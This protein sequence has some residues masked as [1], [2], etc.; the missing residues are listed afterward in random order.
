MN[1]M[2]LVVAIL[3]LAIA[4]PVLAADN[5]GAP[6]EPELE[7]ALKRLAREDAGAMQGQWIRITRPMVTCYSVV[8]DEDDVSWA[9]SVVQ[10]VWPALQAWTADKKLPEQCAGLK[11]GEK[12][13][14]AQT[15]IPNVVT[16]WGYCLP[17]CS[18]WVWPQFAPPVKAVG[19]YFVPTSPPH[20]KTQ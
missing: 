18:P 2:R 16:F 6:I 9:A 17:G 14:L 1:P 13:L 8:I 7:G 3:A 15:E 20:F 4:G 10:K 12:Y 19:P 5:A 11:V